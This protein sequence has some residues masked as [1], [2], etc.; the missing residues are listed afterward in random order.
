VL[1]TGLCLEVLGCFHALCLLGFQKWLSVWL[2]QQGLT[3][4]GLLVRLFIH[5]VVLLHCGTAEASSC[6]ADLALLQVVQEVDSSIC[7]RAH[8]GCRHDSWALHYM[9]VCSA[10]AQMYL[11]LL[12][13][14]AV[15]LRI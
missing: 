13:A 14:S 11:V 4:L 9:V 1:A 15:W 7:P 12:C 5:S 8:A 6:H 3:A 10:V 2:L